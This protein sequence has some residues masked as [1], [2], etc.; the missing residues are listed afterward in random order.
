MSCS[1]HRLGSGVGAVGFE[2]ADGL[3]AGAA[4]GAPSAVGELDGEGVLGD[5]DGDDGVRVGAPE[6]QF[7]PGDQDDSGGRRAALHGDR[8]HG[9]S[10]WRSG[11]A[12]SPEFAGLVV[13]QGVGSGAQQLAGVGVEEHQCGVLDADADAPTSEDLCG[14]QPVGT[15]GDQTSLGDGAIEFQCWAGGS[16]DGPAGRPPVA[17]KAARSVVDKCERT[18]LTRAPAMLRWITSQSAQKVTVTPAWAGPSQNC[19]PR[20]A[21]LPEAGTTRSTSTGPP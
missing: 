7:L 5:V 10:R 6:R 9:G 20:T 14:E 2:A 11:G 18:V 21:R 1:C 19:L 17:A 15:Q 16:G 4:K 3:G 8:L 12:S 13:S